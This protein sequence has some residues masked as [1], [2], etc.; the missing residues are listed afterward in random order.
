MSGTKIYQRTRKALAH[1]MDMLRD[2]YYDE[3]IP[4]ETRFRMLHSWYERAEAVIHFSLTLNCMTDDMYDELH[5]RLS[6]FYRH[7]R[8]NILAKEW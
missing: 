6:R 8:K 4:C 5:D 2:T 7:Y 1:Y 3:T